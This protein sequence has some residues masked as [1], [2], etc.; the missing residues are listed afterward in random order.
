MKAAVRKRIGFWLGVLSFGVVLCA[1]YSAPLEVKKA[2]AAAG[3][4]VIWW[5]TEAIPTAATSL[6]PLALYPALSIMS[7]DLVA[8]Q[9]GDPYVF[10]FMGGFLLALAMQKSLLHKRIALHIIRRMGH[11]HRAMLGGFMLATAIISLGVSNTATTIMV[12]PI[13]LAVLSCMPEKNHKF[14]AALMMGIAYASSIGGVAT[15]IGKP[16]NTIFIGQA[17]KMLPSLPEVNFIEWSLIGM[18]IAAGFLILAWAYMAFVLIGNNKRDRQFEEK[19]LQDLAGLGKISKAEIRVMIIFSLT[20]IAWFWR[21]DIRL[22]E[23]TVPGWTTLLGLKD[24]HD[25]AIASIAALALFIVPAGGLDREEMLL[26]WEWA[27]RLP[28]DILLFFGAGFALAESF[29]TS[30]LADRIAA[31]FSIL[32]GMPE[33]WLIFCV[34]V[35]TIFLSELM[36]NTAL[37]AMMIPILSPISE[38][39]GIHPYLLMIPATIASS[40]AFM[41]PIGTPPNAIVYASGHVRMPQMLKAGFVLNILGAFWIALVAPVLIKQI[42]GS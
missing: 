3:L 22:G 21:A 4:M 6:V 37:V 12:L 23:W 24:I 5:A 40:F 26:D 34:C 31:G 30:G 19:I 17:K 42:Y 41:M 18:P 2:A 13:G 28:W 1:P 39:L 25:G 9:Y 7:M 38:S 11:G 33:F 32:H 29:R 36:S 16:T 14:N 27:K 8:K 20:V 35:F 10:L 15:L